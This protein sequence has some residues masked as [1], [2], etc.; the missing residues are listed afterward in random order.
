MV[1]ESRC[2]SK[3]MGW[4][5]L[6]TCKLKGYG[7]RQKQESLWASA[8]PIST[9]ASQL[10][11]LQGK[12]G[13]STRLEKKVHRPPSERKD[14][15]ADC[16]DLNDNFQRKDKSSMPIYDKPFQNK[17]SLCDMIAQYLDKYLIPSNYVTECYSCAPLLYVLL[18]HN[19]SLYMTEQERESS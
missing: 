15:A 5:W 4:V 7:V 12:R 16:S 1:V 9:V 2:A 10:K 19:S 3:H 18:L 11:Q 8:T 14:E 6:L 13:F 17:L